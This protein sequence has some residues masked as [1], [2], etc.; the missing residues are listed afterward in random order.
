[1]LYV[2]KDTFLKGEKMEY[3]KYPYPEECL[4]FAIHKDKNSSGKYLE[5]SRGKNQ[6]IY[7]SENIS[8]LRVFIRDNA[9][10]EESKLALSY[11]LKDLRAIKEML[12][13]KKSNISKVKKIPYIGIGTQKLWGYVIE[14]DVRKIRFYLSRSK[15]DIARYLKNVKG[16]VLKAAFTLEEI[17]YIISNMEKIQKGESDQYNYVNN[18]K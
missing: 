10:G 9:P 12:E 8:S 16:K 13:K 5:L 1:M 15:D 2:I 18:V 6:G 3:K 7:V 17:N 14:N 4:Y 11:S